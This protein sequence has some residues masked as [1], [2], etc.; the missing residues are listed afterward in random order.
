MGSALAESNISFIL[1]VENRLFVATQNNGL[2]YRSEKGVWRQ[3]DV[4][5]GLPYGP[6]L[7]LHFEFLQYMSL[8]VFLKMLQF[9]QSIHKT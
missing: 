3:L 2:F 5:N 1:P 4:S 7:S 8:K 9:V 6:I